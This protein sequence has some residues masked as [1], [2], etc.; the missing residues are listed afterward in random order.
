[1]SRA[2]SSE[3]RLE[4]HLRGG[5][6]RDT[7]LDLQFLLRM[8]ELQGWTGGLLGGLDRFGFGIDHSCGSLELRVFCGSKILSSD[9][10]GKLSHKRS[11]L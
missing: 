9:P 5:R 11:K 3:S 2:L 6:D 8:P 7:A 10:K 1:M 4:T